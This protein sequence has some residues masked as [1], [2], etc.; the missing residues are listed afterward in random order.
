MPS[1]DLAAVGFTRATVGQFRDRP[2]VSI[3][4]GGGSFSGGRRGG[5]G[6]GGGLSFG[7]GGKKRDVIAGEL[8]VQLRRRSDNTV[9]WEGRAMTESVSG[10]AGSDPRDGAARL[11]EAMFKDFPGES[12]ITT[13]VK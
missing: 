10:T 9:V 2:P 13:T 7:I 5:V 8:Q 12:G 11:A 6:V 1:G 3:G 4:L